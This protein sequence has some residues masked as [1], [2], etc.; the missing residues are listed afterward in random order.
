MEAV[1]SSSG[2]PQDLL[3][4]PAWKVKDDTAGY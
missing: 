4:D 2:E 3:S 1:Q